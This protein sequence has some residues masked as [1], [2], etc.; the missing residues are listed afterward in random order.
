MKTVKLYGYFIAESGSYFNS[1]L[2]VPEDYS[3]LDVI[4]ACKDR[5]FTHFMLVETMNKMVKVPNI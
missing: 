5:C 3:M 1:W 4:R 2:E